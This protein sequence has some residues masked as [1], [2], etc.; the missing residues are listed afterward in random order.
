MPQACKKNDLKTATNIDQEIAY[1]AILFLYLSQ[2]LL[3]TLNFLDQEYSR[4]MRGKHLSY[5]R[6]QGSQLIE[7]LL[8]STAPPPLRDQSL[9]AISPRLRHVCRPPGR[10]ANT[11]FLLRTRRCNATYRQASVGRV[12]DCIDAQAEARSA[13]AL[14]I[15]H[16]FDHGTQPI[17]IITISKEHEFIK[18]M[19]VTRDGCVKGGVVRNI[20]MRD[21]VHKE[22]LWC[23]EQ[24][25]FLH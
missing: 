24:L 20:I 16:V 17:A 11:W 22:C 19:L 15:E 5:V 2:K 6:N 3:C 4:L 8:H 23:E 25:V 10:I 14:A 9:R 12:L 7:R 18:D 21:G 13:F 1:H